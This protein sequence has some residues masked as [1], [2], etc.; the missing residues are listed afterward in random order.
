MRDGVSGALRSLPYARPVLEGRFFVFFAARPQTCPLAIDARQ[1]SV[2]C[3]SMRCTT[4]RRRMNLRRAPLTH[5]L[6]AAREMV[7]AR[8][9]LWI[10]STAGATSIQMNVSSSC[11]WFSCSI[12]EIFAR[13][14]RARHA[15]ALV[16]VDNWKWIVFRSVELDSFI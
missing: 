4:A 15:I 13:I 10:P 12:E 11:S 3:S 16:L 9:V 1:V 6:A 14:N 2:T 5:S 8:C 7:A